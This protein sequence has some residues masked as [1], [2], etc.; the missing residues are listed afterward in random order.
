MDHSQQCILSYSLQYLQLFTPLQGCCK[1]NSTFLT[2]V[3]AV[4]A[5]ENKIMVINI[6]SI[7]NALNGERDY[8]FD[9]S[10]F[11]FPT[12]YIRNIYLH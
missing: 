7:R 5:V 10:W 2:D 4:K 1:S 3:V 11:N 8:I 9:Y 6:L 12:T